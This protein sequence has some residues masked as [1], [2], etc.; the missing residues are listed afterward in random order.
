MKKITSILFFLVIICI[1]IMTSCNSNH[2][3]MLETIDEKS[4][5]THFDN[6][7]HYNTK[8]V[9]GER[10]L[11]TLAT[12]SDYKKYIE[13]NSLSD[14]V[15]TYEYLDFIG[16]FRMLVFLSDARYGDYSMYMYTL[17]DK[18]FGDEIVLYVTHNKEKNDKNKYSIIDDEKIDFS[19]MRS[20]KG[21]EKG[22]Y[23]ID[24]IKYS[25]VSGKLLS[26][27]WDSN[28]VNY[29]IM[30]DEYFDN[31]PL[32]SSTFISDLLNRDTAIKRLE[33]FSKWYLFSSKNSIMGVDKENQILSL[34]GE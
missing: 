25:Y 5:D 8:Q 31:Y 21:T 3:R 27:E 1:V 24:E 13:E 11:I 20:I 29:I 30:G 6:N 4:K 7:L 10:P 9:E 32:D 15:V 28:G 17:Y 22:K 33:A 23:F 12:Y 26:I 14:K 16:E 34:L 2:T 18:T 19:D